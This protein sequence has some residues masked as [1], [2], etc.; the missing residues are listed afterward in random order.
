MATGQTLSDQTFGVGLPIRRLV[1]K[2]LVLLRTCK[3]R[4]L[5]GVRTMMLPRVPTYEAPCRA[6]SREPGVALVSHLRNG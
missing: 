4:I 2:A 3:K 5:T 6:H 1:V